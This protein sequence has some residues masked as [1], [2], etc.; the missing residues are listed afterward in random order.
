VTA[1]SK[2][3]APIYYVSNL[4]N[5]VIST[6]SH[7]VHH[8][9]HFDVTF[10]LHEGKQRLKLTL[11]PNHDILADDAH[12]QYL[13]A[14]G[15][16][17]HSEPV[18]RAD[19]RVFKGSAWVE[20]S[21]RVWTRVGW[22]RIYVIQDGP[23]ALFEGAF[24]VMHDEHHIQLRS[25]YIQTRRPSDI[26]VADRGDDFMV[27]YRDSDR[28]SPDRSEL[29]RSFGPSS[30]EADKLSF[31]SDPNHP[32]FRGGPPQSEWGAMS[33]NSLFGL[34]KRQS[35]TGGVGGNSGGVNL[36][37][38]I[39]NTAGCPSSKRV[40]LIGAAADCSFVASF[41]SSETARQNVI[42]VVN[43][44][45]NLYESTFNISLG[46]Q[47]LTMSDASCPTGTP[48][49]SPWNVPCS[50]SN[51][52]ARLNTFSSWRMLQNDTN[53]YWTLMSNCP[54]D[55]EVGLSWLGQL[56]VTNVNG[57]EDAVTGANIVVR[58]S[59]LWQVFAY[60]FFL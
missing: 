20:E 52:T 26:D 53:A 5:P 50:A 55:D 16:I 10:A 48:T 58:T 44:A 13:D 38:T 1:S 36:K 6:P 54:T 15:N 43:T 14:Q 17:K 25:S 12:I 39:G 19:H 11:E 32:V 41:N 49:A 33:I 9:S 34:S 46:L 27:V 51:I 30:C 3:P 2:A 28:I 18:N 56:C 22:A 21:P 47:N 23:R 31:N 60:V 4:E 24:S 45:S 57:A 37:S 35:D 42:S 29:K 40:A 59:S 7:R 8:L